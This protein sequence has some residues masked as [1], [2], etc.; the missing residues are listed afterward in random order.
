MSATNKH[1]N[2]R[3]LAEKLLV[4]G[5][6]TALAAILARGT[7]SYKL[8]QRDELTRIQAESRMIETAAG[9]VE[10]RMSG[11]GPA[12]LV[13]HG[14]PGGYD[15]GFAFARL[16]DNPHYTYIALSRPGYLRTPLSNGASPEEQADLYAALLDAL[17]IE[18]TSI[19]GISGGGP[20]SLQ[21]ALRHPERCR[22]LI[23][24][25]GV[26]QHYSEDDVKRA[27]PPWQQL[28]KQIYGRLIV[29]DPLLYLLIALLRLLPQ[30]SST[31]ELLRSVALYRLREAGY[32]NDMRQFAAIDHYPLERITLP[33]LVVH[34]TSDDEVPFEHAQLLERTLSHMTLLA[35]EGGGHMA[36]YTHEKI[37]MPI[38]RDF[39]EKP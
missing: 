7:V 29:F 18:Q 4:A 15:Q 11:N 32:K 20:S 28:L 10:Y 6:L 16:I 24:I 25:S 12:I 13:I 23:M 17:G 3:K 35:V 34:G 26:A 2:A 8:W 37:V 5:G 21:F 1:D 14:S 39:L 22:S 36:F 38:V 19:I 33:T 27:M 31:V 30:L 9:P